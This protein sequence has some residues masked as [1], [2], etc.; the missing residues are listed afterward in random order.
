M[1]QSAEPKEKLSSRR[2]DAIFARWLRRTPLLG[3]LPFRSF[4]SIQNCFKTDS[5]V[6]SAAIG[7]QRERSHL[8]KRQEHCSDPR[9]VA[10]LNFR[11]RRRLSEGA[12]VSNAPGRL[13]RLPDAVGGLRA[14]NFRMGPP[15][16][17]DGCISLPAFV[18]GHALPFL[19]FSKQASQTRAW[20]YLLRFPPRGG[21]GLPPEVSKLGELAR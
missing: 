1:A 5:S 17:T 19:V 21:P 10:M 7:S 14:P 13:A 4:K 12:L 18:L 16:P 6:N 15:R 11:L 9:E 3:C 20:L 8:G 2:I